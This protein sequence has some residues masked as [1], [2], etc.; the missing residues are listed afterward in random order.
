MTERNSRDIVVVGAGIA[1]VSALEGIRDTAPGA[2]VCLLN[3][4]GR[5]PYKRTKL[6]KS[7]ASGFEQDAFALF[8][9]QWY[10]DN[11]VD[12]LHGTRARRIQPTSHVLELE[13]GH[14]IRWDRLVLATGATP[15]RTGLVPADAPG[16]FGIREADD[17]EELVCHLASSRTVAVIGMGVLGVEVAE[18]TCLAGKQVTLLNRGQGMMTRDLNE[19][20]SGLLRELFE[21][22]DVEL[23][24]N[25]TL[26]PASVLADG[27][28]SL[29]LDGRERRFDAVVECV[30]SIPNTAVAQAFGVEIETGI[31]V[32]SCL[33]TS[34]PDILAAGD[35][36][37]L[38]Q[39]GTTHLWHAAQSQG[40]RAGANAAGDMQPYDAKPYRLKC[41]PF[42]AYF[43]SMNYVPPD[44]RPGDVDQ[45]ETQSPDVYQCFTFRDGAV[46]GAVMVG[47]KGRSKIYEKAVWEGWSREHVRQAL[48]N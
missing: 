35:A 48:P 31:V 29:M 43:F 1:G 16:A 42:G 13:N 37:Q 3:G 6:S 18:Q 27:S 22:R 30:G 34:C 33:R 17:V 26:Q 2:S 5:L 38:P 25:V 4:E 10:A 40:Y 46:A 32:D 7:I 12:V 11:R 41:E 19:T 36:I 15:R 20:A 28:F 45:L 44:G 39:F 47:D 9:E 21:Q 8:D 14:S 23:C 24:F